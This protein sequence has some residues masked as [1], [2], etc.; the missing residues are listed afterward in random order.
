L[1]AHEIL[2][3]RD[4]LAVFGADLIDFCAEG[5]ELASPLHAASHE[6]WSRMRLMRRSKRWLRDARGLEQAP[7]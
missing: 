5:V 4:R 6:G 2:S 3:V 7:N 1:T